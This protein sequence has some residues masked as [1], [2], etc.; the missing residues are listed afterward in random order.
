MQE[1]YVLAK[2]ARDAAA[3]AKMEA[4]TPSVEEGPLH[5]DNDWNI[6]CLMIFYTVHVLCCV[7]IREDVICFIDVPN[8]I[9]NVMNV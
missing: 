9:I 2:P 5:D 1:E 4:G 6:R 3:K 8:I 7:Y